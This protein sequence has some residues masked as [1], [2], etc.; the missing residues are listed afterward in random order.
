VHV[1]GEDV[2]DVTLAS[3]RRHIGVVPQDTVLFN[4]SI[5]YNIQ[6]A[7][8]PRDNPQV[9]FTK[10]FVLFRRVHS[11]MRATVSRTSLHA[12]MH[13]RRGL[14]RRREIHMWG[15]SL[16]QTDASSQ[17]P[18]PTF[19]QGKLSQL[20][21]RSSF[22]DSKARRFLCGAPRSSAST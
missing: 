15:T 6:Y 4:E 2:R 9:C 14:T 13:V 3:L 10:C 18:L 16:H 7:L 1:G 12:I 11:R 5:F 20:T 21:G 17:P 19:S 22:V 8:L